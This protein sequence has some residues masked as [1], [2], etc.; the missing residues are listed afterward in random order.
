MADVTWINLN[1]SLIILVKIFI[2]T[3]QPFHC[4]RQK[5]SY[6]LL[7]EELDEKNVEIVRILGF[8]ANSP[9]IRWAQT[10]SNLCVQ[11]SH[12]LTLPPLNRLVFMLGETTDQA[13]QAKI[14]KEAEENGDIVQVNYMYMYCTSSAMQNY[15]CIP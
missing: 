6:T 10:P 8:S 5:G 14:E 3:H 12:L 2:N 4:F 11:W 9:D 1:W 13:I 15:M 7:Y